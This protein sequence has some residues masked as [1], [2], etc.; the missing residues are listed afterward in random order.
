MV[1][2]RYVLSASY[3]NPFNSLVIIPFDLA[4]SGRVRLNVY[5]VLGR[6]VRTLVEGVMSPGH[7]TIPWDGRDAL[8]RPVASGRY[9]I[10]LQAEGFSQSRTMTL[11][12]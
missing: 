4:F 5:D 10:R 2:I 12:R 7:H 9:V 6:K 8:G 1:P 3:P 11:L